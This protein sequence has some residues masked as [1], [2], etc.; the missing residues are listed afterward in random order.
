[1]RDGRDEQAV[2][3]EYGVAAGQLQRRHLRATERQRQPH[4]L[5]VPG[6]DA[7]FLRLLANGVDAGELQRLD[8]WDVDRVP[9]G[10]A[11]GHRA[12]EAVVVVLWTPLVAGLDVVHPAG[13]GVVDDRVRPP[14]LGECDGVHQRLDGGAGLALADGGVHLAVNGGVV[15]IPAANHGQ[16]LAGARVDGDNGGVVGLP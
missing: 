5:I 14:A 8:R 10:R 6:G 11:D 16:D 12:V 7:D 13:G 1:D 15:V 2:V 3:G 9:E 4:V